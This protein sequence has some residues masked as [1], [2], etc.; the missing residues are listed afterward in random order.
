MSDKPYYKKHVFFCTRERDSGDCCMNKKS[1]K[2]QK[3]AQDLISDLGLK[4]KGKARVN[5]TGCLGRCGE[6]P[7]MV[8]YPDGVWYKY[9]N[10]D[11]VEEIIRSHIVDGKIV[12]RLKI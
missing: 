12:K 8:V 4:G 10:K 3:H 1:A 11:D 7:V 6:G 9:K 2:A 5:L